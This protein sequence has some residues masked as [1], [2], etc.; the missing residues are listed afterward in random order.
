MSLIV[1]YWKFPFIS[2]YHFL[3]VLGFS[4]RCLGSWVIWSSRCGS[5]RSG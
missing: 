3:I 1:W 5:G 2:V 4:A